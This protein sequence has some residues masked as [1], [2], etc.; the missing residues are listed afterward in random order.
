M[1]YNKKYVIISI[2]FNFDSS[3]NHNLSNTP[4]S[5]FQQYY[6]ILCDCCTNTTKPILVKTNFLLVLPINIRYCFFFF[7]LTKFLNTPSCSQIK[8]SPTPQFTSTIH[9][10][11]LLNFVLGD[12]KN[13]DRHLFNS[14]RH[15]I[16]AIFV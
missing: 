11:T 10:T 14:S 1:Q 9:V 5:F 4:K 16:N 12:N 2:D 8:N 15:R 7:F 13:L 3:Y 6:C